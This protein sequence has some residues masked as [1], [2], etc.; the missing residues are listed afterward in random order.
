[1]NPLKATRA[2]VTSK[3]QPLI[4]DE[5]NV[6]YCISANSGRQNVLQRKFEYVL[7]SLGCGNYLREETIRRNTVSDFLEFLS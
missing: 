7:S 3:T 2:T 5:S 4:H 1:M 6:E